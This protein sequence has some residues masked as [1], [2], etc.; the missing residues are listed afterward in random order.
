MTDKVVALDSP[1]LPETEA[2]VH[3]AT[4][5]SSVGQVSDACDP[6]SVAVAL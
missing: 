3:T 2:L 5:Y 6:V 4:D 1:L